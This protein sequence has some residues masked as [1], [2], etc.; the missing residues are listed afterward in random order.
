M[1]K[2]LIFYL[3]G[4]IGSERMEK[5]KKENKIKQKMVWIKENNKSIRKMKHICLLS[6]IFLLF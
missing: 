3:N 1:L 2:I 5:R 6:V 4:M